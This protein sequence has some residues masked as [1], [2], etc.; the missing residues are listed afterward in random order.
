VEA[1]AGVAVLLA[2]GLLAF[3]VLAAGYAA[4]MA[5]HAAEA[6]ALA[7]V[8][9]RDPERAARK[10]VP[11]WPDGSLQVVSGHG[12]ARVTLV[13]PSPLRFLRGRVRISA[14]AAVLPPR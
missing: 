4:A 9:G 13:P 7:I 2:A 3:Q 6:A 8:N 1:V 5:D 10:A 12:R 14:E 11:G